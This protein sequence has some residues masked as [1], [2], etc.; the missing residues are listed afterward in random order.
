M[1]KKNIIHNLIILDESGSMESFK[2]QIISGFNETVQ[3]IKGS[4]K[5]FPEQEHFVSLVTFN[6]LRQ[7]LIHFIDPVD[8][9][10]QIDDE[11]YQPNATTPLFDAI[12]FAVNKLKQVVANQLEANVLVTIMTDGEENASRE[13]SG[14]DIKKLIEELKQQKWTFT[15]IGTDHDVDQIAINLSITNTLIFDKNEKGIKDMFAKQNKSR[16]AYYKKVQNKQ[17]TQ[18]NFFDEK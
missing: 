12:G 16:E 14:N 15:Y 8:K 1:M 11:K 13:F 10:D 17:D 9:L 7:N 3:T 2:S 6:S 5:L 18:D 4:Q